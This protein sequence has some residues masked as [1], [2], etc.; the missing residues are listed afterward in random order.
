MLTIRAQHLIRQLQAAD[1]SG[2]EL[3]EALHTSRRTVI[4][5]VAAINAVLTPAAIGAIITD[6]GYHLEVRNSVKFHELL[7]GFR[8]DEHTVL[9]ELLRHDRLPL[10]A[11]SEA[12]YLSIAVLRE[13]IRKLNVNYHNVLLIE[14]KSGEGV[15][16][17]IQKTSRIDLLAYLI[18]EHR[19]FADM[20][21]IPQSLL[22]ES[23]V[24][25]VQAAVP[26]RLF[27]YLTQGQLVAQ[28]TACA[29]GV[30]FVAEL[31]VAGHLNFS[32]NRK[33]PLSLQAILERFYGVKIALLNELTVSAVR[34][35]VQSLRNRRILAQH[36]R[37]FINEIFNHLCRC[38]MFPTF[39]DLALATQIEQL[40][41][42]DPFVFDLAFELT[43]K[44]SRCFPKIDIEPQ[45]IA[46]YTLQTVEAPKEKNVSALLI[47]TQQAVGRINQ[48]MI[49][50]Q[51]PNVEVEALNSAD[52]SREAVTFSDY[53]LILV[54][55]RV[56]EVRR[57]APQADLYFSGLI[58]SRDLVRLKRRS[59]V[60]FFEQNLATFFLPTHFI[61]VTPQTTDALKVLAL[62]LQSFVNQGQLKSPQADELLAREQ[63][64]NQLIINSVSVP[65]AQ[66]EVSQS[67]SVFVIKPNTRKPLKINDQ[68]I[69]L[70]VCVLVKPDIAD[71]GKIFTFIYQHLAAVETTT[72]AHI[73]T[74]DDMLRL[75][76]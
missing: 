56:P 16:L 6:N 25:A 9:F 1:A 51:V 52:L 2:S 36:E 3:A 35:Q 63:M 54:N 4:R 24:P 11:L 5:D 58:S 32:E 13:L 14:I 55:G 40:E 28:V 42:K 21:P 64:G 53:D 12:T 31:P 75:W 39:V 45:F 41:L 23:I 46:L 18:R 67:Y 37:P 70:F 73:R 20:S 38:A 71:P 8:S 72:L 10:P 59:N 61:Q 22:L 48:M 76:Q 49:E 34:K 29:I 27:D 62:G 7:D 69:R 33:I 65:H 50:E 15:S 19:E 57:L 74:Y 44:L 17:V 26:Q 47:F 43:G 60:T 66:A 68:V 30:K